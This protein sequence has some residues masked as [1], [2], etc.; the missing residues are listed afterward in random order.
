M[1][2]SLAIT[3]ESLGP[4]HQEVGKVLRNLAELYEEQANFSEADRLYKWGLDLTEHA[5]GSEHPEV[6]QLMA[7]YAALQKKMLEGES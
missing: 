1:W 7:Q 3:Q 4:E 6:A 5:L 2:R